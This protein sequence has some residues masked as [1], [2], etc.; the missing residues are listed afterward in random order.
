MSGIKLV[1]SCRADDK[2]AYEDHTQINLLI[3][4]FLSDLS[5]FNGNISRAYN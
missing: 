4:L 1:E 5:M 2:S 3:S